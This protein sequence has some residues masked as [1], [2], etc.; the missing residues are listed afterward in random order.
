MS[1]AD[2]VLIDLEDHVAHV[3]L[4]RPDKLNAL[5]MAMFEALVAA[6]ARI[7][8]LPAVRA[9]VISGEGA[10]FCSGL[11]VASLMQSPDLV[12]RAFEPVEGTDANFVQ[13][14]A[15]GIGQLPV[16]VI[17]AVHGRCYGGGLQ[18]ALGADLRVAA[19]DADLSIMEVRWGLVPDMGIT[20][21]LRDLMPLDRAKWLTMTGKNVSGQE[22]VALGLATQISDDPVTTALAL[23][24]DIAERS[25]DAIRGA[26]RLLN[27]AWHGPSAE[28]L[29]LEATVQQGLLGH[30]AQVEAVRAAFE[31]R[32]ARFKDPS[33]T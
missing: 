7:A 16:P 18:I 3:R 12:A 13:F 19:P 32:P 30:P 2:R 10:S 1:T 6:P 28:A 17:A 25:P 15:A 4:N 27:G 11:D 29:A 9:V 8:A 21:A 14:A 22:A 20:T 26:K 24:R 31:K 5:D 33:V 23:A